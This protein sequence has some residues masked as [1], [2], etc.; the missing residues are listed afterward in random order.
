MKVHLIK[1]QSLEA[2]TQQHPDS[3]AS[4]SDW[5][6]KIKIADWEQ[7]GD[8]K[9]TYNRQIFWVKA[10]IGLFLILRVIIIA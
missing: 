5:V 1:K 10:V 7:P 3:K 2:F 8:M 6:E 4:M 9:Q